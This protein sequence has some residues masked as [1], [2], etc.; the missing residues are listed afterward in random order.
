MDKAGAKRRYEAHKREYL[1][2]VKE[3]K[4]SSPLSMFDDLPDRTI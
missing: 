2:Y 4:A 3:L 1:D